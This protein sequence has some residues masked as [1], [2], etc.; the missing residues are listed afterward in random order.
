MK[1]VQQISSQKHI[2]HILDTSLKSDKY[3]KTITSKVSKTINLLRKF[4]NCL[5]RSSVTAIY[6]SFLRPHLDYGDVI[7]DKSYNTSFQ[8]KLESLQ[9]KVSFAIV[10]AIKRS[11]T[12]KIYKEL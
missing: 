11:S 10:G 12:E 8:Q 2:G 3:T 5:P 1:P 4:K 7:F 9:D 6:K